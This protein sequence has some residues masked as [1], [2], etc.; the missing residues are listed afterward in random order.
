MGQ[1]NIF[2]SLHSP[3]FWICSFIFTVCVYKMEVKY[4]STGNS[5]FPQP[6]LL[7]TCASVCPCLSLVPKQIVKKT[8]T[9]WMPCLPISSFFFIQ[10]FHFRRKKQKIEASHNKIIFS[11]D[12]LWKKKRISTCENCTDTTCPKAKKVPICR[13]GD[14]HNSHSN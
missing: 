12:V 11:K 8:I 10:M 14:E 7:F 4:L 13:D 5:F 6:I 3:C 2:P 1:Q 9:K